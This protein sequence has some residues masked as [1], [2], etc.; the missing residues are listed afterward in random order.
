MEWRA[1]NYA[2]APANPVT[3]IH[4]NTAIPIFAILFSFLELEGETKE[5]I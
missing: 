3:E 1:V 2:D 5:P 4:A